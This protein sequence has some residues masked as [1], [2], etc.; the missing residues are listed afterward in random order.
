MNSLVTTTASIPVSARTTVEDVLNFT[1]TEIQ[2]FLRLNRVKISGNK[3]TLAQRVV[4]SI[5]SRYDQSPSSEQLGS[6]D[7]PLVSCTDN[8]PSITEMQS[9][10]TGKSGFFPKVT[11]N[12]IE[13]YLLHSSHRTEDAGKM[14]CYRQYIRGLNFYKEGYIHKIMINEISDS[15]KLCYIRSKCFPSMQQGVYEQWLLVTKQE[16][17]QVA[18][19]NCTCPAGSV[20]V[21]KNH[22][23]N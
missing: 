9:G 17:F 18:K 2:T 3:L 16:P 10:W 8:V 12:D 23:C 5:R 20:H 21:V 1:K 13:S 15:S 4:D 6:T 14:H 11:I 22:K 7:V 19:A